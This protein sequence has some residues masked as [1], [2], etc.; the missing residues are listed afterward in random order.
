MK[1]NSGFPNPD[2]TWSY[3]IGSKFVIKSLINWANWAHKPMPSIAIPC[4][5]LALRGTNANDSKAGTK[6]CTLCARGNTREK[7]TLEGL[8]GVHGI[9]WYLKVFHKVSWCC[10]MVLFHGVSLIPP[11]P[12]SP[13]PAKKTARLDAVGFHLGVTR[14]TPPETVAEGQRLSLRCLCSDPCSDWWIYQILSMR[15]VKKASTMQT[16]THT[17]KNTPPILQRS[18]GRASHSTNCCSV[19]CRSQQKGH[20]RS[21]REGSRWPTKALAKALAGSATSCIINRLLNKFNTGNHGSMLSNKTW[22]W[23]LPHLCDPP[24]TLPFW[25]S[26]QRRTCRACSVLAWV[27]NAEKRVALRRNIAAMAGAMPYSGP[28]IGGEN[29]RKTASKD[30]WFCVAKRTDRTTVDLEEK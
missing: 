11:W 7:E 12:F 13:A 22:A 5:V 17:H 19:D 21:T 10:F 9:S 29:M 1:C 23:I 28:R 16:A 14:T 25:V 27:P 30:L 6:E 8:S 3:M 15:L 20:H 26:H 18:P 4:C 2:H 24:P